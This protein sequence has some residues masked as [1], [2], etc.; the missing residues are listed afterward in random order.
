M[1]R[2]ITRNDL[3]G[4]GFRSGKEV[5]KQQLAQ[6]PKHLTGP[7]IKDAFEKLFARIEAEQAA[8]QPL[9]LVERAERLAP[10][11]PICAY[12]YPR[13]FMSVLA[14]NVTMQRL[15]TLLPE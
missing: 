4:P 3:R 12:G 8:L 9:S 5:F 10:D 1:R 7:Q 6:V 2:R 13:T 14:G 15:A 11:F